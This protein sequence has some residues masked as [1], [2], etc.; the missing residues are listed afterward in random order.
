MGGKELPCSQAAAG[1]VRAA[2]LQQLL[3]TCSVFHESEVGSRLVILLLVSIFVQR[4]FR[5]ASTCLYRTYYKSFALKVDSN[6][7]KT[8]V[9]PATVQMVQGGWSKTQ[10]FCAF[11]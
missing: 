11:L 9:G 8:A 4:S 2:K 5:P 3:K 6:T 7:W 1:T 10:S